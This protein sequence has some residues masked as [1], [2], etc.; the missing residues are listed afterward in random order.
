[1]KHLIAAGMAGLSLFV[2][3]VL[4]AHD[5]PENASSNPQFDKLKSLAGDWT[6]THDG[7][8][9]TINFRVSSAGSTVI[10]TDMPGTPHEMLTVYYVDGKDL[11]LTHYCGAQNQPHMKATAGKDANQVAF[12]FAG[13][14]NIDVK[15]DGHMHDHSMTLVDGDNLKSEWSYWEGGKQKSVEVF[16]LKRKK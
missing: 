16:D 8:E 11:V 6:M 13:G 12:A 5:H 3:P 9:V 4:V 1:M 15:K 7:Q 2:T 10:E 14:S